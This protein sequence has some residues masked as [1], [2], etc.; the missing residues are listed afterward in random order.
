MERQGAH[1]A[2]SAR[3]DRW[4]D[5]T[6][7]CVAYRTR[8]RPRNARIGACGQNAGVGEVEPSRSNVCRN[9]RRVA[10]V[11]PTVGE[12]QIG[13]PCPSGF[14]TREGYRHGTVVVCGDFV[15]VSGDSIEP[16]GDVRPKVCKRCSCRCAIRE[17]L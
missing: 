3:I 8:T 13:N 12:L 15:A 4:L 6:G 11:D 5:Q 7:G 14:R 9:L 1:V 16:A 2:G 10:L 17:C